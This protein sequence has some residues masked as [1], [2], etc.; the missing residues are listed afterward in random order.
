MRR[1]P[2][3]TIVALTAAAV[4][5][6]LGIVLT[7]PAQAATVL[8][9]AGK[10]TT[11]SS[12]NGG[13]V[14][15]NVTDGNQSSYWESAGSTFPQWVQVD[16]GTAQTVTDV[17]MRLPASWGSRDQTV[18]V[19]GSTNGSTFT[20]LRAQQSYRFDQAASNLVTADVTDSSVRY[21]RVQVS[22]NNGW[23][24]AQL[25]ELEVLGTSSNPDPGTNLAQGRPV[26]ASSSTQTY[27]ASN[28]VDGNAGT[29]W[30]GGG[31]QYPTTLDVTLAQTAG[32]SS[33]VVRLNP[34]QAWGPR[35]QT[36]AVLGR[37]GTGAW[38]TLAPSA[39]YA[40][41]PATGN[42]VTVPVSGTVNQ[43]RLQATANT[44][45]P[46]AQVAEL[47]VF[48]SAVS[49]DLPDLQAG[50]LTVSPAAPT[51]S[52][53][54]TLTATI[55]NIGV[56][57]SPATTA[58]FAIGGQSVGTANV[59]A[60][61]IGASTTVTVTASPRAAG[62]YPVTVTVDP[63]GTL[64]EAVETNNSASTSVTVSADPVQQRP[65]LQISALTA[66]PAAPT[67]SQAIT[68][69]ATVRNAGT[70]AST[71]TN[72]AFSVGGT[73][74]GTAPVGA[75]AAGATST[76]TFAAG[77]R[78]A[79]TYALSA[80]ADAA[81]TVAESDETNNG[82]TA[83]MTVTSDSTDPAVNLSAGR[84]ATASS[85]EWQFA[86]GNAV[87]GDTGTYWEGASG[88]YP[89]RLAVALAAP[90]MLQRV[91]VTLPPV[92][93]WGPRT[94][95]FAVETAN[96]N[97]TFTT[98]VPSAAYAFSNA[99]GN[100][101]TIPLSGTAT[102]VRLVLTANTG[103]TNGQVSE[104]QVW[105]TLA[106]AP[107][108]T[109][110]SVTTSPAAPVEGTATTAT[111]VVANTGNLAAP[112]TT[113]VATVDGT[114]VATVDVPAIAAGSSATVT[115]N[116]GTRPA[117]TYTL[118]ARADAGGTVTERD[119]ANN[120]RTVPL[121]VAETPGPD[122]VVTTVAATPSNPSPGQA[123]SFTVTVRN[124]G[125]SP[126]A[127]TTT[128]VVAGGATLTGA[129]PAL[130]A[131]ASAT[132]AIGGT[133]TAV[134]GGVTATA[135]ADSAGVVAETNETNNTGTLAV[136]VGRGAAVPFTTYEA[137][138]GTYTG[139]LVQADALRTFGHTNFGTESSGRASVRLSSQGQYVQFTS[140]VQTNSV[141]VRSSIPD[142]ADG[143]GREAT[144]SLYANGQ[145]VQKLTLSSKHAWLYGTS[146]DPEG[147]TNTPGGD[148]RRLFDESHALLAQ[149]YPVGTTFRLQKDAGDDAEFYY[150]DLVDL[151]QVADPLAKPSQCVSITQYGA[152]PNDGIDDS[153]AIQAAVTA[154]QNGQIPCVWIPAGQWRQ[155]K[156][157]LTDDPLNR[158]NY[159]QVGISDTTIR[160][161]GMWY[162]Q[163]YSLIE[164]QDA[165]TIN[166]PHEGNFGFDIDKNV[167]ISDIAIFGSGRIRGN[168]AQQEGGVGLNGR[169]G[170]GTKISNVWIEHANVAV[171]V[172]RDY[173]NIPEL[174]G[175]AD[176]LTFT[177]MRIRDTYADG[178]N[179]SNGTRN[180]S[181]YNSSFRTTGDD[182]LAI[183]ANPYVKD[184]AVDN[185]HDNH[186]VNN[187]V[188]LPWR[189][190]GIAIYGGRDNSIENNIVSDTM[191]YPGIML[192]TDHSPLPFGGTTLIANNAL[193]R[194]G[195]AFWNEDQEFG[196]ITL[197]PST[198]DITGVTIRDTDVF[199]STYDGIQFKN[200][201]GNMPNV[202]I[203][204]VR[205]DRSNN[206]SGILAMSGARGNA[207]ITG[208]TITSSR[209]G[210]IF[211]EPGSQFVFTTP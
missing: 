58:S 121:V 123:V 191:N 3:R 31:G 71:A 105:G 70:A 201:G 2:T 195:G 161:A 136:V 66:S 51:P 176:G 163:L 10:P 27:V 165:N 61:A 122:L 104:L 62:S 206:G 90:A 23:P 147:L 209:D 207:T 118:V 113:L 124:R 168:N 150:V 190:N 120:S 6:P 82:A 14:S 12:S 144:L 103:A 74:A 79:G 39:A 125:T 210:D 189:A 26:V 37:T 85:Q 211:K 47:Q 160:G 19:Q 192:A 170:T 169:F 89:S 172:G 25:S 22:A 109:V 174:W 63:A 139:T 17:A 52:S 72:V 153:T 41:S 152:V 35:T 98:A 145:F 69:S 92:D 137:E 194:T 114:S 101:V 186:F 111:V 8:L 43:V 155:E 162:S 166:H 36:F 80:T 131:G 73:Q 140:T 193:Y 126:A 53:S 171:W 95:T 148:A 106:P 187:T 149:S 188:A 107:D 11:A 102:D 184:T 100:K 198:L 178:I 177:G 142:S 65:D 182:S 110:S 59:G 83:S 56:A 33:V 48:G 13:Y 154:D 45:A 203:S 28:A 4:V 91:V 156:K 77:A 208:T 87:D 197:F 49:Q 50:G 130:A 57:A 115:A 97:G 127:A 134:A 9:S 78:A 24:A 16:L 133:W 88:Q 96:G 29:Y 32:L 99:T 205:I 199:D 143:K 94:Q 93:A 81:G 180:S 68:L 175:P 181:V 141:V 159:N 151:E 117:G 108:L 116:L 202:V 46:G 20:T 173:S 42:Q 55:R 129:T 44:G 183:W 204:N 54:L 67:S 196:A 34:D 132:V 200:G 21:V 40:F 179:F 18:L 7:A 76:V 157:I 138:A 128:K 1:R 135:T 146:D 84:P 112:A 64:T 75:L 185:A 86:P 5:V 164:P 119:E 60:L 15:A 167:Q 158:G 30:E 38:T